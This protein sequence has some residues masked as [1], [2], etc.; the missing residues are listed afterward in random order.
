MTTCLPT[1]PNLT[2]YE[3]NTWNGLPV[4]T[5]HGPLLNEY[6]QGIHETMSRAV[7]EYPRTCGMRFDLHY[8]PGW[9]DPE[10]RH[11]S[12]FIAS[13][14]AQVVAD[15]LR[16]KR[17]RK[18]RRAHPCRL[19]YVWVKEQVDAPCPHYHVFAFVNRDAYFCLGNFRQR[20]EFPPGDPDVPPLVGRE[21][22]ADRIVKA[23]ASALGIPVM[24]AWRLVH[25]PENPVYS[26]NANSPEADWQFALA[27]HRASYFAKAKTKLYGN[28]SRC[29]GRSRD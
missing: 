27:F 19:R 23:W 11:I 1:N 6:L 25:F 20:F 13:L 16:R 7:G 5:G 22:M 14:N 24:L 12:R 3:G 15:G 26:I 10:G 29:F 21:N 17:N 8:P 2:L 4:I 9:S 28:Y 18:D